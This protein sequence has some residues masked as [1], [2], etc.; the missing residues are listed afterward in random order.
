MNNHSIV[1]TTRQ[2]LL[3]AAYREV[4][5]RRQRAETGALRRREEIYAKVPEL[6]QMDALQAGA[7]TKAAALAAEGEGDKAR[8]LLAQVRDIARR[9]EQLLRQRGYTPDDL[10]PAYACPLCQDTGH[11]AGSSAP[12]HCVLQEVKRMRRAEVNQS[13][14]L[15]LCSFDNFSLELYPEQ[16]EGMLQSPRA[17]MAG[18]LLDCRDYAAD[19]GPRSESLLLFGDAGLGKT[20]LALAIAQQVLDKGYDV[21]YLSAQ[22]AFATL[23]D[24]RFTGGGELFS[25]MLEA[26]LL[27]LDDLGTEYIDAW[28]L[29]RLYELVNTRQRRPTIYTTNICSHDQLYQRYTEKIA[30]RLLGEC[31]LM[32]FF[33]RDIRLHGN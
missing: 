27:I 31:A 7:G 11:S 28:V 1:R 33:G 13:G 21:I 8:E 23:S 3:R 18:I 14:P 19:F 17:V 12:C 10:A 29:S 5:R 26:D 6:A 4:E 16:M 32:R 20:H 25:A 24:N 2:E 22:N 30:S 9:R 15:S